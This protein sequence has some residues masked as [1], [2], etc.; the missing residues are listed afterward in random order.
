MTLSPIELPFGQLK[1]KFIKF[2]VFNNFRSLPSL[3]TL[4]LQNNLVSEIRED[5]FVDVPLLEVLRLDGNQL[6]HTIEGEG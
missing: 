4:S 3:T 2:N 5:T 1:R 6:S